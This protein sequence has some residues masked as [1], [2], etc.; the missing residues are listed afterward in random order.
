MVAPGSM[1]TAIGNISVTPFSGQLLFAPL[2][3]LGNVAP[4]Q[5]AGVNVTVGGIAAPVIYHSPGRVAFLLPAEV[6]LGV[7]EV[8]IT[9]QEGYVSKGSVTVAKN[10][11]RIMTNSDDGTGA[12][13]ALNAGT[14]LPGTFDINTNDNLGNDKRTRV[15]FFA[16]GISGSVANTDT[17]NDLIVNGVTRANFAE[18]VIVEARAASG[19]TVRLP[20]EF[21]GAQGVMSGMDQVTVVLPSNL[22]SAGTVQLTLILNGQISNTPTII[23]R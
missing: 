9:S 19:L 12:A 4:W 8:L 15:T 14:G 21:A 3:T 5:L 7:A 13:T 17:S 16:T 2:T 22:K 20:V 6:P 10:V 18:S 1:V 11:S 23:V